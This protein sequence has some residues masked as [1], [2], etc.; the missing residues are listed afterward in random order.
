MKLGAKIFSKKD[1]ELLEKVINK[2]DFIETM[3]I[4]S[5]NYDFLKSYGKNI[6]IHAEHQRFGTNPADSSKYARNTKSI[7]FALRL[8]DRLNA[9]KVICHPGRISNRNCSEKTAINFFK[10][11]NDERILIENLYSPSCSGRPIDGLCA[12]PESTEKFLK[13]TGKRLCLDFSHAILSAIIEKM[14]DYNAFIKPYL[15]MKPAHFHFSDILIRKKKDHLHLG[16]GN[17]DIGYYK[18]I[19]PKRAEITLETRNNAE[20]L[21]DDIKLLNG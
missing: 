19:F 12:V 20:T 9:G 4:R 2:V 18:K 15:E 14:P 17:L 10:N 1:I 3:A 7:N 21:L 5:Q 6:V 11:I 8:A 16:G 13:Q